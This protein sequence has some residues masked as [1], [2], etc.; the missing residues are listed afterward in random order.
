MYIAELHNLRQQFVIILLVLVTCNI[1]FIQIRIIKLG[2]SKPDMPDYSRPWM[3][4]VAD[5]VQSRQNNE[6]LKSVEP[7][8]RSRVA[9]LP[10]I[11]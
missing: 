5:K 7:K 1:Q 8:Q 9:D 10:V 3:I 4:A 6:N 11:I 2:A